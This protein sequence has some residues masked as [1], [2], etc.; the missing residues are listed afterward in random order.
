MDYK[1]LSKPDKFLE[2]RV[3]IGMIVSTD[4]LSMIRKFWNVDFFNSIIC[5]TISS[6]VVEYYDK[7][8]KAPKKD[9]E[10]MF[11]DKLIKNQVSKDLA[12]EFEEDF[13]PNLVDEY[14]REDKFNSAYLYD[15]TIDFF[16]AQQ[17]RL[18]NEQIEN[19]LNQ[20]R[21]EEAEELA[22][23]FKPTVLDKTSVGLEI[24]SEEA[25]EK[26]ER[27]FNNKLVQ[28]I[29]YPDALGQMWNDH[30]VRGG[31]IGLLGPEKRGKTFW[32]IEFAMRGLRQKCNVAFFQAGDMTEEQ[33]LRR[34][35][36]YIAQKSDREHYCEESFVPVKDCV[37]NQLDMCE[38]ENRNCDF[39][40]F[41]GMFDPSNVYDN[42]TKEM[43]VERMSKY[44]DYEPCYDYNCKKKKG[45]VWL[46]KVP[47]QN[48]L[49][50]KE[51]TRKLVNFFNRYKRRFKLATYP[52]DTLS[53]GEIKRCLDEWEIL[54]GFVPDVVVVDYADIMTENVHEFRHRQDAIWKKLRGL[55][56]ERH[57]LV[58]TATQ[59][60]ADSYKAYTLGLQNFSEDK[61]KY[62]HVTAMYGLNQDPKGREK[63]LGV[64]RINELVVREGEFSPSNEVKVL[65][66][67]RG[68]RAF[69]GSVK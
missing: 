3:V 40:V 59:A 4:Y 34:I 27:A 15:Q 29:T 67:L 24:P 18:H 6:W 41:S 54:D 2:R 22:K 60:D 53:V 38:E 13:L 17:L 10:N 16:K 52:A 36:V 51:A 61:R 21:T 69:V 62:A 46:K 68:G 33:M 66:Y 44:P 43:I 8:R 37:F 50:A 9:I 42:L 28:V 1:V 65:Q 19:L 11:Y 23:S 25:L 63:E 49:K 57:V 32:L 58:V 47:K 45:S 14:D 55:S 7:Y 39:G 5:K 26:I 20:G 48:P 35:C 64:M 31:F 30:L 56:E 12:E